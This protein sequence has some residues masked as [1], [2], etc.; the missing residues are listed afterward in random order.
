MIEPLLGIS[1]PNQI[2]MAGKHR[3]SGDSGETLIIVQQAYDNVRGQENL[4]AICRL[5][6]TQAGIRLVAVEGADEELRPTTPPKP[7][8]DLINVGSAVSAGVLHLQA[9]DPDLIDV[10]G[11]DEL[12]LNRRSQT[13]MI[14][15]TQSAALRDRFLEAVRPVLSAAQ[16]SC[17]DPKLAA[18]RACTLSVS[19]KRTPIAKQVE[20]I[21]ET[22]ATAGL[23]LRSFPLIRRFDEIARKGR[24]VSG[25]RAKMQMARFLR[26]L[27]K[28]LY[29]WFKR[30]GRNHV[31]ID[32]EKAKPVL[33]YWME[34]TGLTP[35]E[36]DESIERRGIERVLAECKKWLDTWII[37]EA[38]KQSSMEGLGTAYAFWEEMMRLA[39]RVGVNFFDL[40]DLRE[41]VAM[42]RDLGSVKTGLPDELSE[43]CR[44]L[45]DR[46]PQGEAS[47]LRD[48]ED[49][50]DS[51][52]RGLRLE[53]PPGEAE[54]AEIGA[55]KIEPLLDELAQLAH[56]RLSS[57]ITEDARRLDDSLA[58]AARF[59]QLSKQRSQHM[60]KKT[61]ELMRERGEDRAI[62]VA[63]GF[64]ERAI[65]RF[66]ED[67][68]GVSWSVLAAAVDLG[69][70]RK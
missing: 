23:D 24:Q 18:L 5:C 44:S 36:L 25:W 20:L 7:V 8:R 4:E 58:E 68:P 29:N 46:L 28:R 53:V 21:K 15:V 49:R 40:R 1:I 62:L 34:A 69:E 35:E 54:A 41:M 70:L 17:Y 47:K 2:V 22:A 11:V 66:L 3:R 43:A 19:G 26:R 39:L 32:L 59:L 61:L 48:I 27:L 12:E 42:N 56:T 30:E 64:H 14:A 52:Y 55:G 57:S 65:T 63:G 13:A 51:L 37:A 10:W 6:A 16:S 67:S 50:L 60:A 31:Q 9:T 38:K 33:E 45:I